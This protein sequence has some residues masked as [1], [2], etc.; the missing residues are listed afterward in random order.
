MSELTRIQAEVAEWAK[1]NFPKAKLEQPL[2]GVA[3]ECGELC[4]AHLKAEQGIRGTPEEH[5][6]A[7]KDAIGDI[8]IFLMHYCVL[9]G[10]DWIEVEMCMTGQ[11]NPRPILDCISSVGLLAQAQDIGVARKHQ[12]VN[13]ALTVGSIHGYCLAY[14]IDFHAA[15]RETWASVRQRDWRANKQTG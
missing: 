12:I 6:A 5:L 1:L 14:N 7:K 3:E 8:M 4:H 13:I 2:I 11:R 10:I 15:I 9:A